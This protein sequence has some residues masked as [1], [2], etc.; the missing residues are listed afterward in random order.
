MSEFPQITS[1]QIRRLH[2]SETKNGQ[3]VRSRRHLTRL[4]KL[5]LVER[6]WGIYGE[7]RQEYVYQLPDSGKRAHR[8]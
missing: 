6:I 7:D 3:E 1:S 5:G 4:Y 8:I 2:Y